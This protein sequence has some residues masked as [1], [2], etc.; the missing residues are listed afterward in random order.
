MHINRPLLIDD[1]SVENGKKMLQ[2]CAT[3]ITLL[4]CHEQVLN[5][6]N[7]ISITMLSWNNAL[8]LAKTSHVTWNIQSKC[9]V[10]VYRYTML[11]PLLIFS[12]LFLGLYY[13]KHLP[14]TQFV[15]LLDI[16]TYTNLFYTN[17]GYTY[18]T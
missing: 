2:V 13:F 4:R 18:L 17:I 16:P 1:L 8:W 7:V 14:N 10:S 6:A 15:Y 9:I 11:K 5:E 3:W 12:C